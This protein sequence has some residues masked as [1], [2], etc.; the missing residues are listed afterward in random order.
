MTKKEAEKIADIILRKML[1]LTT[2][3]KMEMNKTLSDAISDGEFYITDEEMYLG[4]L[5][6]LETLRILYEE[7]QDYEKCEI[8]K[9]KIDIVRD[10][11]DIV[12]KRGI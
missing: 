6:R 7:K 10:R 2:E 3:E 4:E 8:I 11:L 5:A 12:V 1:S 9:H